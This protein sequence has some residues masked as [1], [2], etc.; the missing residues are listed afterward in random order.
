ME[1]R[2][3][4]VRLRGS[5]PNQVRARRGLQTS[6]GVALP[7]QRTKRRLVVGMRIADAPHPL[8]FTSGGTLPVAVQ[9]KS[10]VRCPRGNLQ[11]MR[12]GA[13]EA[14]ALESGDLDLRSAQPGEPPLP[15][16]PLHRNLDADC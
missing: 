3:E 11:R 8:C 4:V 9:E 5:L 7:F 6:G 1:P 12:A 14:A 13:R 15:M 10:R 16:A 2:Q